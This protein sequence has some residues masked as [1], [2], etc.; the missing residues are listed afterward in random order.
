MAGGSRGKVDVALQLVSD[1]S[2]AHGV[3]TLQVGWA[4]D[5]LPDKKGNDN[6]I[7]ACPEPYGSRLV[8]DEN[9]GSLSL[10]GRGIKGEGDD[11]DTGHNRCF[12]LPFIP[13]HSAIGGSASGG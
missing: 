2:V 4:A 12:T 6:N 7:G 1:D 3:A 5:R 10:Y 13:S 11:G 8:S 9:L